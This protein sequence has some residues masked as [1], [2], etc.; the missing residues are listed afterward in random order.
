MVCY[1]TINEVKALFDRSNL[2]TAPQIAPTN[3]RKWAVKK[4]PSQ[5]TDNQHPDH[6]LGVNRRS[7]DVAVE[8]RELLAQVRQTP[9]Y[10]RI[11]PAQQMAHW[12]AILRG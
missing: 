8:R 6:Q 1:V 11:D 5:S 7:A 2:S 9:R 3:I 12:N 10:N 4:E